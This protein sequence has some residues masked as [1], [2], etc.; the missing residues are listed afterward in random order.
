MLFFK[1]KKESQNDE[2]LAYLLRGKK[3]TPLKALRKFG[4]L[5]LSARIYDLRKIIT[6]QCKMK[7]ENGKRFAEYY[8]DME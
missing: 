4:C 5:R 8:I 3:L 1:T 6:I 7:E 2:I